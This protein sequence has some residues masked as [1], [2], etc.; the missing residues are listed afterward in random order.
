MSDAIETAK[1]YIEEENYEEAFKLA[2]KR[3]GKDDVTSYLTIIDMVKNTLMN[4]LK[5]SLVPSMSFVT[6][7]FPDSTRIRLMNHWSLWKR[8]KKNIN[9]IH[10]SKSHVFPK[11]KL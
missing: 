7:H 6:R 4:T 10:Q 1:L 3:H 8:Q 9:H 11:R 2:K 5:S